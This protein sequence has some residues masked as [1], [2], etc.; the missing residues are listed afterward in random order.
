M[1]SVSELTGLLNAANLNAAEFIAGAKEAQNKLDQCSGVAKEA[2][3]YTMAAL[4]QSQVSVLM[5]SATKMNEAESKA[6]I[7]GEYLQ[8]SIEAALVAEE[9][10]TEYIGRINS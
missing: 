7:A 4:G 10:N 2:A 6:R 3:R 9:L 5:D 8:E 1:A